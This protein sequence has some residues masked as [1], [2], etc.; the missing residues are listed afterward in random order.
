MMTACM[1]EMVIIHR[2][3]QIFS[4]DFGENRSQTRDGA[5]TGPANFFAKEA[6]QRKLCYCPS[7]AKEIE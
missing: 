1:M 7:I 2:G 6:G 5:C 4:G 3:S